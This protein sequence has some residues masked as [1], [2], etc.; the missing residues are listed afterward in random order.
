MK[1][2]HLYLDFIVRS[3]GLIES[4][5]KDIDN[6]LDTPLI[7]DA[8]LRNLQITAQAALSLSDGFK[9]RHP[10]VDWRGLRSFRNILVHDYLDVDLS[11]VYRALDVS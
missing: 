1:S 3:T 10:A 9:L 7:R 2:D 5:I 4:Y 11:H 8:V 6:P